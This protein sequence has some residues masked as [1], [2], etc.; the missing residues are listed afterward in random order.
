MLLH[1]EDN[2]AKESGLTAMILGRIE[3]VYGGGRKGREIIE[4]VRPDEE[5]SSLSSL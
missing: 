5:T 3:A 4:L 1:P 2:L